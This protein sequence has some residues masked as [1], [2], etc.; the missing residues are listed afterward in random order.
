MKLH[1][2]RYLV[3][4]AERGSIRGAARA[5][6]V[7]QAAV[8]QAVRELE[9]DCQLTLFERRSNGIVLTEAGRE[10]LHHAQ[11]IAK[12]MQQAEDDM[13][14]RRGDGTVSRLSIGV[15]PWVGQTLLP[16]MLQ[17]FIADMP[18]VQLELFEG[19]SALAYPKLREGALDLVIGRIPAGDV[20]SDLHSTPLFTY[21]ASVVARVGHPRA[22]CHSIQDLLDDHWLL[23]Y[24]PEEENALLDH[25]FRQHRVAVP[26]TRIHLVHSAS[27][28]L[29]IVQQTDMLTYCPWPLI[30]TSQVRG[31]LQ[32]LHLHETFTPHVVG[33]VRRRH[34]ALTAPVKRFLACF[35]SEI[36][37]AAQST[38]PE[39]RRI[40]H[41]IDVIDEGV[42]QFEAGE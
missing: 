42:C 34:E 31:Q 29:T 1:Q 11:L 24:A 35:A 8:T 37:R 13:A 15:T 5:L 21:G 14:R 2:I 22:A 12:Q 40:F 9:R 16:R 39:M 19:L 32:A 20:L 3:S 23:N 17:G 10:L 36:R 6:D 41:S 27:M 4:I 33:L 30:E 7:T 25:V 38:V 18:Q 28:M 26:R